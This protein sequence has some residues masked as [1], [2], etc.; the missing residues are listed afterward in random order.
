M[1][2]HNFQLQVRDKIGEGVFQSVLEP[3]L[4]CGRGDQ[5]ERLHTHAGQHA[6]EEV[7][8]H[9][10][11][12]KVRFWIFGQFR[13]SRYMKLIWGYKK[14]NSK[15][16][17]YLNHYLRKGTTPS[18]TLNDYIT[19]KRSKKQMQR[20]EKIEKKTRA[21]SLKQIM[22]KS[23]TRI[24]KIGGQI[25]GPNHLK[26]HFHQKKLCRRLKPV[27]PRVLK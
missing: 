2:F 12:L 16:T 9:K 3:C 6:K 22:P 14:E 24:P 17:S 5:P 19:L 11:P 23:R 26:S 27:K 15:G 7:S 20:I 1:Q 13:G 25:E 18:S 21:Q 4:S 8:R 10:S